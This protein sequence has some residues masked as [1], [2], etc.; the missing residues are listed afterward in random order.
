MHEPHA[1]TEGCRYFG[2]TP[3]IGRAFE[4][5]TDIV[6]ASSG[7]DRRSKVAAP[8]TEGRV[9]AF[10]EAEHVCICRAKCHDE[11]HCVVFLIL[12]T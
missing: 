12:A 7:K 4:G 11:H 6:G 5:V 8:I 1:I 9:D 2:T 3:S 10:E